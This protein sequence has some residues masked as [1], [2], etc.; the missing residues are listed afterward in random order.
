MRANLL[1]TNIGLCSQMCLN[2]STHLILF[3]IKQRHQVDLFD[4]KDLSLMSKIVPSTEFKLRSQFDQRGSYTKLLRRSK[5]FQQLCILS[6]TIQW[7]YPK[8]WKSLRHFVPCLSMSK[9]IKIINLIEFQN[10]ALMAQQFSI[11]WITPLNCGWQN[12]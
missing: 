10:F 8:Y 4:V 2:R 11:F 1:K 7:C 9:F 12:I 6:S 3:D 5:K